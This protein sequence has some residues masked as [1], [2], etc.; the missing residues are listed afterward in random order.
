M[1]VISMHFIVVSAGDLLTVPINSGVHNSG[2]CILTFTD[3]Q[4]R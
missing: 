3:A 2:D 4:I 1:R